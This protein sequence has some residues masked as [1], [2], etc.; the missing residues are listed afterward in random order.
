MLMKRFLSVTP[1]SVL[2]VT[3]TFGGVGNVAFGQTMASSRA[4]AAPILGLGPL[5]TRVNLD[6]IRAEI[7]RL[8]PD[9]SKSVLSNPEAISQ[10][11]QN[12]LVR[13]VLAAEALRDDLIQSPLVAAGLQI[14]RDH[15]LSEAR[16]RE[17]DAQNTPTDAALEAHARNVYQAND[18]RFEQ[19][20]QTRV[21]HILLANKGPE[22]LQQAKDLI[23]QL[24]VGASFED[25]AKANSIDKGTAEKGGDLG[26]FGE[27]KMVR[28][29]EDAVKQLVK[30]GDLS[31]PVE[32]QFGY[33]IIR[34]EERRAKTKQ[35]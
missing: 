4:S 34:L 10:V 27:G 3:L 8:S 35:P 25:I 32:T 5:D 11:T 16:L 31:P 2:A 18:A 14:A 15:V 24:K 33:H 19:P 7:Q 6:D 1:A 26:F 30:P 9:D 12:L 23:A 20:E 22:S 21:R 17:L 29:F 13:R 28:P